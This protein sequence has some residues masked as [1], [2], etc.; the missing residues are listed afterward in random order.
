MSVRR[1][2]IART[3]RLPLLVLGLIAF[4]THSPAEANQALREPLSKAAGVIQQILERQGADSVSVGEF[5][6]PPSF[7][8]SAGAGFKKVLTE[9]LE[10]ANVRVRRIGAPL[11]VQGRFSMSGKR[12]LRIRISVVNAQGAVLTNLSR[13]LTLQGPNGA[14]DVSVEQGQFDIDELTEADVLAELFGGTIDFEDDDDGGDDS[15]NGFPD[16]DDVIDALTNPSA[17]I[18]REGF[19]RASRTSP[20]GLRVIVDGRLARPVLEDG[21]PF[22]NIRRGQSFEL[23][24]DNRESFET[25]V[26]FH[27]D[28][29]NSFAF[30][31]IRH[32]SGPEA[33]EPKYSR[34]IVE[35][36]KRF[37]LRGWHRTNSEVEQFLITDF[38]SSAAARVGSTTD[39]GMI[40]ASFRATWSPGERPPSGEP[41]PKLVPTF[42]AAPPQPSSPA[43]ESSAD[44][45]GFGERA[46]QRVQEDKKQREY[47]VPRA[48]VTIRYTR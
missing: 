25:A 2:R 21:I 12:Q 14:Q 37:R 38:A 11:G 3:I 48:V 28:G 36:R 23:E 32:V 47:G 18:D 31:D 19:V 9:E 29:V 24:V 7:G 35:P 20:F 5:L 1:L 27:L 33:G 4:A 34:W 40:T 13:R 17:F 15:G 6:G 39:L 16:G 42:S 8:T 22:V 30:S 10:Q 45:V 44:G 41:L 43:P 26:R 46:D